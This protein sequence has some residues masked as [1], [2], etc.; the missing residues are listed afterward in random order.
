M[1]K[2]LQYNNRFYN[3][4][5]QRNFLIAPSLARIGLGLI[6]LYNYL[7]LYFQ[8]NVILSHN[9]IVGTQND[10]PTLYNFITSPILF[11]IVFHCG[12]LFA[13]LYTIG[14]YTKIVGIANFILT[15]SFINQGYLLTDGGDNLLILLLF[16]LLFT[17]DSA[18]FAVKP[19]K[20]KNDVFNLIH[21]FAITACIIQIC[22]VYF[23]SALYQINGEKWFNGTALYY[24]TQVDLY[25]NPNLDFLISQNDI[26]MTV[27]TYFSIIIKIAFPFFIFNKRT[28]IFIA[29]NIVLF[30]LGISIFMGLVTFGMTMM[31]V[32]SLI[33]TDKEYKRYYNRIKNLKGMISHERKNR[34][35]L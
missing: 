27:L 4:C 18:Y 23:T 25:S 2:I 16:Y 33:F 5:V 22:I 20:I 21:N 24:I 1:Q 28:K 31:I 34:N 17:N 6:I 15:F 10:N 7:I 29:C 9:G 30:H 35:I 26:I 8:R 32:E 19:L 14:F 13:V 3:F 11:E 12:I